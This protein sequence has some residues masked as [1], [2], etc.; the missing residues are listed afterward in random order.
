ML[1]RVCFNSSWWYMDAAMLVLTSG[2]NFLT[3][4]ELKLGNIVV[5]YKMDTWKNNFHLIL[6]NKKI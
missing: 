6:A 1:K 2:S 4:Q 5:T 3:I